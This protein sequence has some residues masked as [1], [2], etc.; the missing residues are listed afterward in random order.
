MSSPFQNETNIGRLELLLMKVQ[1]KYYSKRRK[2]LRKKSRKAYNALPAKLR[3]VTYPSNWNNL[4]SKD[5]VKYVDL[6]RKLFDLRT[7]SL[8]WV[9][10]ELKEGWRQNMGNDPAESKPMNVRKK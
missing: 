1:Y 6:G 10:V 9:Q 5:Q 4:N 7:K 3:E 8:G 2:H